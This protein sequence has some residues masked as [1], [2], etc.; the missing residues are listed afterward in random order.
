MRRGLVVTLLVGLVGL[1]PPSPPARAHTGRTINGF[2]NP[3]SAPWD[4]ASGSFYVSNIGPG[5]TDPMGREPDGYLSRISGEGRLMAAKWV[6]GLR[7]PKG[8]HRRGDDLLVADV[9]QVVVIDVAGAKIRQTIDLDPLGAKFP[10]DVTVDDGTGDAYVS[11]MLR[12]TIYRI[13][14]DGA[15]AEVWLESE[16][17]DSPNGLFLDGDRLMVASS[18]TDRDPGRILVVDLATKRLGPLGDMPPLG[19]L[20]GIE[21]L[22]SDW[23]VTGNGT[24]WRVTPD[25]KA[26]EVTKIANAADLGLRPGDRVAAV[27][28]LSDNTVVFLTLP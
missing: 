14:A 23:I 22:G 27:P 24:V 18:G 17:L 10:N 20:D 11:D 4:G 7:S 19:R 12:N 21:K 26:S 28:T 1:I 2:E 5:P 25:G 8:I 15:K 16:A 6:T 13:P 3:E 9:G